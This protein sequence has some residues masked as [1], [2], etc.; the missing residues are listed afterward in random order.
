MY[1]HQHQHRACQRRAASDR[2][3]HR[4]WRRSAEPILLSS[5]GTVI[6]SMGMVCLYLHKRAPTF[7][8]AR[9]ILTKCLLSSPPI[10]YWL[11]AS[12]F[13]LAAKK[14][15]QIRKCIDF[16]KVWICTHLAQ[17]ATA[18]LRS[19][20]SDIVQIVSIDA[21]ILFEPVGWPQGKS[22]VFKAKPM[23]RML[24]Y[25]ANHFGV[26]PAVIQRTN[27]CAN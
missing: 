24:P 27:K 9:T 8:T 13:R 7:A 5:L 1:V 11:P 23:L 22:A 4:F 26:E 18:D 14:L 20:N 3:F 17:I 16:S 19:I 10:R 25:R 12:H 6:K 21:Q 15:N 2:Q